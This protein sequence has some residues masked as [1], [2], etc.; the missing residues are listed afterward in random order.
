MTT[1]LRFSMTERLK[2]HKV[3]ST[4][5]QK[6]KSQSFGA[7]PL[8]LVWVV[9]DPEEGAPP[10]Q[11]AFSVPKKAF[12]RA[13]RR[14]TLRRRMREAFRLHKNLLTTILAAQDK[15]F[16]LM[17]LFTAKEELSYAEIEKS[18]VFAIHRFA[19][20]IKKQNNSKENV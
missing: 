19:R 12:R 16:A 13:N 3:I 11:S 4:L 14:N 5:F 20:E 1:S 9:L 7:Y 17:W 8:R 6:D 18:M 10:I 15:R 2:S